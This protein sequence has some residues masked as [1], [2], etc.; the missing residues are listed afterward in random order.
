MNQEML[1]LYSDYLISQNNLATATGLSA[2]VNGEVSHDQV[3]RFLHASDYDSKNLWKYVKAKVRQIEKPDGVLILDDT[4]ED[5]THT[6]ENAIVCWHYSHAKGRHVK[7]MNLLS[8][9]FRYDEVSLPISFEVVKKDTVYWDDGRQKRKASVSKNDLFRVQV[10]QA[11]KNEVQFSYVLADNWFGA[12]DNMHFI[13]YELKKYFIFGVKSNR[14]VALSRAGK[15]RGPYQSVKSLDWK[16]GDCQTVYLKDVSMPVQ[17]LKK[18]FTNEDGSTGTLY[19]V[20]NDLTSD[21]GQLYE[22]YK[23]RWRIEEFHKSIKQNA[24]LAKSPTK[25]E[26]SQR[27]HIFSVIV[28]YCKLEWLKLKTTLNHFALKYKL[29]IRANQVALNELR[30]I[31]TTA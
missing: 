2:T 1:D 23:K 26:R 29:L 24:S 31:T 5:K 3:T 6:D 9:L 18:V 19:L 4:I 30:K 25:I 17:L 22:I 7:G 27:N 12:K 11:A 16:D 14:C 28:A 20:S 8:C 15:Q 13:H 10:K 21:S